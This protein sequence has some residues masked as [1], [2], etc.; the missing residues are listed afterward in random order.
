MKRKR[1]LSAKVA[2]NLQKSTSPRRE[3]LKKIWQSAGS[4]KGKSIES[5]F[6]IWVLAS[7]YPLFRCY[8]WILIN[9]LKKLFNTKLCV[10][11]CSKYFVKKDFFF[12]YSF[13]K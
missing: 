5:L 6:S 4:V 7:S 3:C 1:G 13:K 8:L 2:Y 9:K 11:P 12:K 10:L